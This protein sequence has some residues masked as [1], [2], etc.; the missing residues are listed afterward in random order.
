MVSEKAVKNTSRLDA[1]GALHREPRSERHQHP[2]HN[3]VEQRQK[4]RIHS[5]SIQ[6]FPLKS[7]PRNPSSQSRIVAR[8]F[9][10]SSDHKS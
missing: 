1:A 6:S 8:R 3:P 7:L 4:A 2:R 10:L 9:R 5:A